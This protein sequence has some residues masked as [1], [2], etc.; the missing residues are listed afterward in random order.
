M[1]GSP[2]DAVADLSR[3]GRLAELRDGE[4]A[5]AVL[6]VGR[7]AEALHGERLRRAVRAE[8]VEAT[9]ARSSPVGGAEE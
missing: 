8:R 2:L 5:A 1:S 4:L 9:R 6:E 3:W 7:L